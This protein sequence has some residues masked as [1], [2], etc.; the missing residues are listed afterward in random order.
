M[1][2]GKWPFTPIIKNWPNDLKRPKEGKRATHLGENGFFHTSAYSKVI[3][4]ILILF[5]SIQLSKFDLDS[6]NQDK[7]L[8]VEKNKNAFSE[9]I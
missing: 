3:P 1:G 5:M 2:L 4:S 9:T 7:N 6:I 8:K